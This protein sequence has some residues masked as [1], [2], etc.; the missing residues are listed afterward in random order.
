MAM[1]IALVVVFLNEECFLDVLL[2]SVAVQTHRPDRLLLV[3]DGSSDRSREIAAR[4]AQAHSYARLLQRPRRPAERDR[5][6]S[7]S[8]WVGFQEAVER[9]EQSYD[10]VAKLDADLRLPPHLLEEIERRF[11]EDGSLGIT[12]PRLSEERPGGHLQR[13]RA[14]PEHAPGAAKFYRR[15]CY[16]EVFPLP[17]LLNL[18]IMDEVKARGRGWRTAGF[19]AAGGDP[20]HLRPMGSVDGSLRAFRRWGVGDYVSGSHPAFV[21]FIALQRLRQRPRMVGAANYLAGWMAAAVRR[22]PRFERELRRLRRREQLQRFNT[23][24]RAAFTPG[25]IRADAVD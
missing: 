14:R 12:G 13:I 3:D 24:L 19:A 17:P 9:L 7:A 25:R 16:E 22:V 2:D 23:R 5:L 18:D 4:F 10:V 8:V 15:A 21:I 6:A 20:L 11:E 1:K